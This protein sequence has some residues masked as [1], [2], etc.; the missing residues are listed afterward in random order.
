MTVAL[1]PFRGKLPLKYLLGVGLTFLV[2]AMLTLLFRNWLA[3]RYEFYEVAKTANDQ[4][5]IHTPKC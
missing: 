2:L 1:G 4:I 3:A 5:A